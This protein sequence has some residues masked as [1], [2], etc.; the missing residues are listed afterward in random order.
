MELLNWAL[1]NMTDI[2]HL[3]SIDAPRERIF[4]LIAS[5]SG[6]SR[7]WSAD[8]TENYSTGIIEVAFFGRAAAYRLKPIRSSTSWATEWMCQTGPEWIGTRLMF[9]LKDTST[10]TQLSFTHADWKAETDYFVS[11]AK[12]WMDLILRLKAVAEGNGVGPL[13]SNDDL[14]S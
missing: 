9:E 6:F 11:C 1:W 2:R 8:V 4:P 3:I 10:K 12:S 14:R 13:F 7:W 5:G